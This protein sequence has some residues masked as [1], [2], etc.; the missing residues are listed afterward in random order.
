MKDMEDQ[1]I[2]DLLML[3]AN[4]LRE[5]LAELQTISFYALSGTDAAQTLLVADFI[6]KLPISILIDCDNTY[7]FISEHSTKWLGLSFVNPTLFSIGIIDK[8]Q[9]TSAKTCQ[10]LLVMQGHLFDV[11]VSFLALKGFDMVI[12]CNWLQKL[13]NIISNFEKLSMVFTLPNGGVVT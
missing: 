11:I 9:M 13:G 4:K 3:A 2:G 10:L 8:N 1:E 7:N 12:G 5:E 6:K